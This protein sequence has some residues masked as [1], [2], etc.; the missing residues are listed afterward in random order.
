MTEQQD[1]K[2][3]GTA[4][5]DLAAPGQDLVGD[6]ALAAAAGGYNDGFS[7]YYCH[8]CGRDDCVCGIDKT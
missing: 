1:P 5:S 7:D 6:E 3:D 2:T 4:G 8:R